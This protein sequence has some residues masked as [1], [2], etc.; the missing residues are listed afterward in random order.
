MGFSREFI[1]N[2]VKENKESFSVTYRTKDELF[3]ICDLEH[4]SCN[5]ECPVYELQ[6]IKERLACDCPCFKSGEKMYKFIKD[7]IK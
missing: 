3:E 4:A 6:T 5:S 1:K 7:R 2:M